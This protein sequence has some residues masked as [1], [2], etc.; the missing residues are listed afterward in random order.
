MHRFLCMLPLLLLGGACVPN[1]GT[2]GS[3]APARSVS[4][5]LGCL[6]DFIRAGSALANAVAR[7][8]EPALCRVRNG[9][10]VAT[11]SGAAGGTWE[12]KAASSVIVLAVR[13][14]GSGPLTAGSYLQMLMSTKIPEG[15]AADR[16]ALPASSLVDGEPLEI[17]GLSIPAAGD[18]VAITFVCVAGTR[19]PTA[20]M[21]VTVCRVTD[22]SA[23]R[24]QLE[25]ARRIIAV[26]L[27]SVIW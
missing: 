10:Q 2:S 7:T 26:D 5:T 25:T 4:G 3:H 1:G 11:V 13:A 19:G 16:L 14:E 15:L 9:I 6:A 21:G 24:A 20:G 22:D 18:G 12:E 8:G 23:M 17:A 27:P